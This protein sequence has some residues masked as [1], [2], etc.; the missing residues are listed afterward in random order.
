MIEKQNAARI[1]CITGFAVKEI[2]FCQQSIYDG[3][4]ARLDRSDSLSQFKSKASP[5]CFPIR[6]V[7]GTLYIDAGV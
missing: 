3:G 1:L 4:S 7:D 5:H 6:S 2:Y